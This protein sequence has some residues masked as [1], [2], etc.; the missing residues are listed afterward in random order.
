VFD[1]I[2]LSAHFF[3][4]SMRI[5]VVY[6]RRTFRVCLSSGGA[7]WFHSL[8]ESECLRTRNRYLRTFTQLTQSTRQSGQ[9]TPGISQNANVTVTAVYRLTKSFYTAVILNDQKPLVTDGDGPTTKSTVFPPSLC[10]T[11]YDNII[12][13]YRTIA[14]RYCVL[15]TST[16]IIIH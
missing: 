15:T 14:T 9:S 1:L 16:F 13:H 5:P 11:I 7:A 10:V 3:R 8:F 4:I 6:E 12:R 2:V